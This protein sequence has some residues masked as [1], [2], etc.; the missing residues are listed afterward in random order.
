[1][2]DS[3]WFW[4]G[5]SLGDLGGSGGLQRGSGL[6]GCG[7][8]G[9]GAA[10]GLERRPLGRRG[11]VA[12]GQVGGQAGERQLELRVVSIAA[13]RTARPAVGLEEQGRLLGAPDELACLAVS[14]G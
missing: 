14:L 13:L 10:R 3:R 4:R 11:V 7:R 2:D 8:R 9:S 6:R 5:G 1:V 12:F